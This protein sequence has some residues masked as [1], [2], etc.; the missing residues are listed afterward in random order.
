MW[1][2]RSRGFTAIEMLAVLALMAILAASAALSLVEMQRNAHMGQWIDRLAFVDRLSREQARRTARP[3]ALTI[4]TVDG[5]IARDGD[6][7]LRV[8]GGM[9]MER[10]LRLGAAETPGRTSIFIDPSGFSPTYALLIRTGNQSQWVVVSSVGNCARFDDD[11]TI[12]N[13]WDQ[14][15][16]ND[17]H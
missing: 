2:H 6:A 5:S 3:V 8:P 10:V 4:D 12:E 13:E 14:R 7:L 1:R 11:G 15:S 9:S 16:R 17:A